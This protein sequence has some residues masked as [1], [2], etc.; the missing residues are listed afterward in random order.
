M[1]SGN[2]ITTVSAQRELV[3]TRVFDA[4]RSLVFKAWTE[5]EHRMRWWGP[6][7]FTTTSCEMDLRPGG[8]WRLSMRSPEGR[9]DRQRGIFR[10]I[11]PPERLVFTYAF[12]DAAG[13]PGHE[14]L[15]TV[16][17]A[18]HEGKTKLTVNQAVFKTVAVRDDHVRGWG[19]ALD[20]FAK[21]VA[22]GRSEG[23]EVR[24]ET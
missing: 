11:V 15:V 13:N 10:E 14:T 8:A 2:D 18:E 5:P 20:H 17:F 24:S 1:A 19:E 9:E 22:T 7:G 4:P 16:T 21:Y 3:I 12:E 6:N 23:R